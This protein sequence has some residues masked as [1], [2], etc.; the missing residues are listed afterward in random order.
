MG[1]VYYA[2]SDMETEKKEK[3]FTDLDICRRKSA[4]T[5]CLYPAFCVGFYNDGACVKTAQSV[6]K[7]FFSSATIDGMYGYLGA[8]ADKN[9]MLAKDSAG[10]IYY[11]DLSAAFASTPVALGGNVTAVP[12]TDTSGNKLTLFLS[13]DK[14]YKY[15][16]A[17]GT[18]TLMS[19]VPACVCAQVHSERL[20]IAEEDGYTVRFS[21]ALDIEDWTEEEQGAGYVELPSKKGDIISMVSFNGYLYLFRRRGITRLRAMGDNMNF[22][23]VELNVH[24]GE[25]YKAGIVLCGKYAVFA[26][27]DG[28]FL[29]DGT[30]AELLDD[31]VISLVDLSSVSSCARFG[32][33]AVMCVKL[34]CAFPDVGLSGISSSSCE[35][36]AYSAY[37]SDGGRAVLLIDTQRKTACLLPYAACYAANIGTDCYIYD[38]NGRLGRLYENAADGEYMG[39]TLSCVW[40]SGLTDF[41]LGGG[42]KLM[43]RLYI[44][45]EGNYSVA[46]YNENRTVRFSCSGNS[47]L[48][49][50]LT[51]REFGLRISSDS[52]R[53]YSVEVSADEY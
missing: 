33:C 21:R 27:E 15:D 51:G 53:I 47:V 2:T 4:D 1:I 44:K 50:M 13:D 18:F 9:A 5:S 32:S 35:G 39:G 8:S 49:P 29:F 40:D 10:T 28:V 48:R 34:K 22:Q 14:A 45:G 42:R 19:A 16:G 43:R 11:S 25:I 26:A 30:D 52:A 20:F 37:S 6:E 12:Y 7:I 23:H 24:C 38:E 3:Y 31:E 17:T 46:V 41:S 36:A